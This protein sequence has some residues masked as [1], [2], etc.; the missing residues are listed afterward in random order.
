MSFDGLFRKGRRRHL[1]IAAISISSVSRKERA[2]LSYRVAI[3]RLIFSWPIMR[4]MHWTRQSLRTG[5]RIDVQ[6]LPA[7]CCQS[8]RLHGQSSASSFQV[9]GIFSEAELVLDQPQAG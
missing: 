6:E 4:S 1:R 7:K 5:N 3:A 8:I 9:P 2:S